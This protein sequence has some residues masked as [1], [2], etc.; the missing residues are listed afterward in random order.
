MRWAIYFNNHNIIPYN[1]YSSVW[2]NV[3]LRGVVRATVDFAARVPSDDN[4][5]AFAYLSHK[6]FIN[7]N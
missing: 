4:L 3:A 1:K 2:Y 5:T 7:Y 6:Y